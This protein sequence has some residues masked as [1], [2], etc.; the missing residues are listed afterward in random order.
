MATEVKKAPGRAF[1]EGLGLKALFRMF[2]DNETAEK[3]FAQA[4]WRDDPA[5]PHCGSFNVLSGAKHKTMPYRCREKEFRKRFSVK[6]GTV[7]QASNLDYQTWTIAIYQITTSL[8][9]VS[10]MKL[11]AGRGAV[12]KTAVVGVKDRD[13]NEV[14]AQVVP[15]TK[16]ATVS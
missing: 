10:S 16:K 3:W 1:R 14:R 7:M 5:C 12:G 8:K 15:D 2:P 13:T 4:R 6:T 9:G 11:K